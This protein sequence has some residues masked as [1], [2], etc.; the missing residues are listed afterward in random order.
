MGFTSWTLFFLGP[1]LFWPGSS[2]S[3]WT[4]TNGSGV[5]LKTIRCLPENITPYGILK[6][7]IMINDQ[8]SGKMLR[9][10][11]DHHPIEGRSFWENP[12]FRTPDTSHDPLIWSILNQRMQRVYKSNPN[13][14]IGEYIIGDINI[15]CIYTCIYIYIHL[16]RSLV[17]LY[18]TYHI[19][20]NCCMNH[21]D[22]TRL[23]GDTLKRM[24]LK[25][26]K[27]A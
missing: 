8:N 25:Y 18:H 13:T 27:R 7:K 4:K 17:T 11:L 22:S 3:S 12:E 1:V 24:D 21:V 14:I 10:F 15:I 2:S 16:H 5:C 23:E 26:A 9:S 19:M 6:A 20:T